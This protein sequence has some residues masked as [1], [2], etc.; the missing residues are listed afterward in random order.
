[1]SYQPLIFEDKEE[2]PFAR[3]IIKR[4]TPM[5]ENR[6]VKPPLKLHRIKETT[7][8]SQNTA[9]LPYEKEIDRL[10]QATKN[11][12]FTGTNHPLERKMIS[13]C[14]VGS[15]EKLGRN[16]ESV[17]SLSIILLESRKNLYPTQAIDFAVQGE[18]FDMLKKIRPKIIRRN[19]DGANN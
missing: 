13:D 5:G 9:E 7:P 11:R 10:L 14:L 1:L 2:R 19:S 17:V 6:L 8:N 12:A 18:S 3:G 15:V 4:P 16:L